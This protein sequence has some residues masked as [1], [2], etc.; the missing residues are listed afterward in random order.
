MHTRPDPS[1][2]TANENAAP[3]L[4]PPAGWPLE[5]QVAIAFWT[6]TGTVL[7]LAIAGGA[8][9]LLALVP[10]GVDYAWYLRKDGGLTVELLRDAAWNRPP[11]GVQARPTADGIVLPTARAGSPRR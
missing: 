7:A 4:D 2:I 5:L 9:W 10:I 3:T 11:G 6:V 8:G 1:H